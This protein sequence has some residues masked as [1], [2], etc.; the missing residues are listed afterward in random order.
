M[1]GALAEKAKLSVLWNTGFNLFRDALQ[2]GVM[3]VLVRLLDPAAYGQFGMATSVIGFI[4]V[5]AFQNFIAY[6]IQVRSDDDVHYQDHFTA[7]AFI[8]LGLFLVANL[9]AVVLWFID[10]YSEIAPL[11]HLLSLSFLLEW[12]CE[13]R[14]K[15]LERALDW[16]HL[17]TLHGVGLVVSSVLAIFM[18]IMGSGVYALVVPGMLVTAPF[19]YEL[20]I[21]KGWRPTWQWNKERFNAAFRFGLTRMGS[22]LTVQIRPLLENGLIVQT[23]GYA[24]VGLLGRAVGL[25]T[26]FCQ[27]L[28]LQLMYAIYPVL[29]KVEPGTARYRK[30]SDLILRLVAWGAFPTAAVFAALAKPVVS[31][32]YGAKWLEVIPLLPWAMLVAALAAMVHTAY[33]L[34]LAHHGQGVC[35][36]IDLM[37][38]AGTSIALFVGMPF[39][40]V[41]YLQYLVLSQLL[42][43]TGLFWALHRAGGSSLDGLI[44]ALL[45]ALLGVFSAYVFSETICRILHIDV[46]LFW[47]A[48]LYGF[49]FLLV[50]CFMLRLFFLPPLKE[51]VSYLP[52][53]KT[54]GSL[55]FLRETA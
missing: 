55:L 29:T 34:L 43:L 6:T 12:P 5:F 10:S 9:V 36:K 49:H 15:M 7:G 50:Y 39:G 14:R 2:F 16:K 26:M 42:A 37:I 44:Q 19:I 20:F 32:V 47:A 4:S 38:L 11:V 45:P 30:M 1:N 28:A 24:S 18:G 46:N 48:L 13:L 54:I 21:T 33:M 40:L 52:G 31:T 22:G 3:L 27:R 23:V 17:R 41:V 51:L 53:K 35:L 8:Q 25:S